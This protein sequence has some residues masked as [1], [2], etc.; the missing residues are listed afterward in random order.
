MREREVIVLDATRQFVRNV[1]PAIARRLIKDGAARVYSR[2][3]F[4]IQIIDASVHIK[5]D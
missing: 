3:P 1:H 2:D 5:W 4:M